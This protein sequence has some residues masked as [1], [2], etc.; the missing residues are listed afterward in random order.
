M[1]VF[2][3]HVGRARGNIRH[4]FSWSNKNKQVSAGFRMPQPGKD[5]I[6][7][8]RFISLCRCQAFKMPWELKK[9]KKKTSASALS[10]RTANTK[11]FPGYFSIYYSITADALVTVSSNSVTET[12]VGWTE[13]PQRCLSLIWNVG[14]DN[15]RKKRWDYI[16]SCGQTLPF[17][18][19]QR[20]SSSPAVRVWNSP[21]AG[22]PFNSLPK[23]P[24]HHATRYTHT[25]GDTNTCL[26]FFAKK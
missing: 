14:T 13:G 23:Q 9:K 4:T 1:H 20:R 7:F 25:Q 3:F 26:S 24:S 16:G 18:H 19:L 21:L 10:L 17:Q 22:V 11:R 12:E 5:L 2:E 8:S 15:W 6:S